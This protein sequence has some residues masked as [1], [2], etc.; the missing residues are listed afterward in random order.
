MQS[1][2]AGGIFAIAGRDTGQESLKGCGID[3]PTPC[4]LP[5]EPI[6][7]TPPDDAF[8]RHLGVS[9]CLRGCDPVCTA[10]VRTHLTSVVA[11]AKTL[12]HG[13]LGACHS[14]MPLLTAE[15]P[16]RFIPGSRSHASLPAYALAWTS[17]L[18]A[19]VARSSRQEADHLL[20]TS[21]LAK[22]IEVME[23]A[24]QALTAC[25]PENKNIQTNR[26]T[27]DNQF[28]A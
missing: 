13:D 16:S 20:Q 7:P 28:V 11:A 6:S 18:V 15:L 3:P 23:R 9:G 21:K 27:D 1:N 25:R 10:N 4:H 2:G 24:R 19:A 12:A 26:C 5:A 8:R 14:G 22:T 17:R